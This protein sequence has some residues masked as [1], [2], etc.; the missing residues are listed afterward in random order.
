MKN[1]NKWYKGSVI[2]AVG[3]GVILLIFVIIS[4]CNKQQNSS[5]PKVDKSILTLSDLVVLG[6]APDIDSATV[7]AKFGRPDSVKHV[8]T[9]DPSSLKIRAWFYPKCTLLMTSKG[10]TYGF[11]VGR[12]GVRT[13]RGLSVGDSLSRVEQLY[14]N[15]EGSYGL[16][17]STLRYS[18]SETNEILV[19]FIE[20][21]VVTR[22]YV[23][24]TDRK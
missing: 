16:P 14:G 24:H 22:F 19:V 7:L 8:S 9:A 11:I 12:A 21:S 1:V 20:D 6:L 15:N 13:A 3:K 4:S 18:T 10:L 17:Q 5:S 23:G 2:S